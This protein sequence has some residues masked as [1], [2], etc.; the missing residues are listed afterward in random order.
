VLLALIVLVTVSAGGVVLWQRLHAPKY[1]HVPNAVNTGA[2]I[3]YLSAPSFGSTPTQLTMVRTRDGATLWQYSL[4]QGGTLSIGNAS[5][6]SAAPAQCHAVAITNR[7]VYIVV[8]PDYLGR[9][10][11]EQEL[12]ALRAADGATQWRMDESEAPSHVAAVSDGT[13]ILS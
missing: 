7:I 4:P 1:Q 13:P 6:L 11:R 2:S 10:D 9:S 3:L 8:D 12:T 5:T